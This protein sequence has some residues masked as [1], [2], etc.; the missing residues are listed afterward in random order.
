V[1][2]VLVPGPLAEAILLALG[3]LNPGLSCVDRGGYLRVLVP[4][5]CRLTRRAVESHTR[6]SFRLPGDLEAVMP[7]FKG[8]LTLTED[9][10]VWEWPGGAPP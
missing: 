4:G 5:R 7:S 9:E 3:E 2:P 8:R 10:A 6:S 1:G